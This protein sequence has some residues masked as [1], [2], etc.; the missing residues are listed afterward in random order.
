MSFSSQVTEGAEILFRK[1]EQKENHFSF[2][3]LALASILQ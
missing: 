1:K 3:H 2:T